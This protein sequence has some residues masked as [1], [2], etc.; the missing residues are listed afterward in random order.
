[1]IFWESCVIKDNLSSA[2]WLRVA[3]SS[4]SVSKNNGRGQ[5]L[6]VLYIWFLKM[7]PGKS[8]NN[9]VWENGRTM[10]LFLSDNG[11]P[12]RPLIN[13]HTDGRDW[14]HI[15]HCLFSAVCFVHSDVCVCQLCF[16]TNTLD[17]VDGVSLIRESS[18]RSWV[19]FQPSL[20]TKPMAAK[21]SSGVRF[22][23]N[24]W[25]T[26]RLS[27]EITDI[28]FEITVWFHI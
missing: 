3:L 5:R 22:L 4:C 10:F 6:Q 15:V 18:L 26:F 7:L 1:M 20:L 11:I 16:I 28:K 23:N 13:D 8:D 14:K 19:R 17:H 25:D 2:L 12:F 9:Y 24:L 27:L 21:C